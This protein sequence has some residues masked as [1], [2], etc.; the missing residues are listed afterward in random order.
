M[1]YTAKQYNHATPLSSVVA[2]TSEASSVADKKYFT[3]FDNKLDGSYSPVDG[4]VGLWGSE[5]SDQSGVLPSPYVLSVEETLTI[6]AFRLTGSQYSY[7]VAFTVRFY[8][9]ATLLYAITETDNNSIEYIHYLPRTLVVTSYE[10]T[11]TKISEPVSVVMLHNAYNPGYVK[12]ADNVRV[13][14]SGIADASGLDELLRFDALNVAGIDHANYLDVYGTSVDTARITAAETYTPTIFAGTLDTIRARATEVHETVNMCDTHDTLRVVPREPS[15]IENTIEPTKDT[16][17]ASVVEDV[18]HVINEIDHTI[19]ICPVGISASVSTEL[20]NIHSIM[21]APT[22]HIYGKVYITYTD[23][24][25]ASETNI[26]S[27]GSAYNS[28]PG[29]VLDGNSGTGEKLFMLYEN[30]LTGNYVVSDENSQIGWV[31]DQLS[32][33]NGNFSAPPYIRIDISERPIIGLQIVFDETLGGIATHFKVDY[34]QQNGNVISHEVTNNTM[35]TVSIDREVAN[36]S[37][38]VITV[39]SISKA[40]YPVV[41]SEVPTLSTRLYVGY[42]DTSNLISIDLLEELT[43]DDAIEALGGISANMVTINLDN[44][45][46]EFY[47]NN[48]DSVVAS[49]LRRN[50]KIVP[51]LGVEIVPGEIEWYTLGTFWSYQWDVPV[52]KLTAS[53]VGFD[54]IGLLDTTDFRNHHV[55]INKSIGQLI[56]YVLNDAKQ[57]LDFIEYKIDASLYDIVIPY[58]WFEAASHTAALRKISKCY[59]MHVYCDREGA[60]CASPQ[61]LRMDY[62]Y[63]TWSDKTNVISKRYSSLY[64]TLPNIINVEVKNPSVVTDENLI[65]DEL[66]FD[67]TRVPIRTLNF[68]KPYISDIAISVDCD[69]SVSYTYELYSWGIVMNFTGTG[70]VR[71]IKCSGVVLDISRTSTIS[72]RDAASVRLNGA[73]KRDVTSDFIQTSQLADVLLERLTSLAESDKYDV[74]VTYRGDLS[75]TINDPILLLDGIAPD[76]RYNIKRHEL[77]WNGALSGSAYLNT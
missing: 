64:T 77:F 22:R 53:V 29:Q 57:Q 28:Q 44:S 51:W 7:P 32:D 41:I 24:M 73:I 21:K 54:T 30:D 45:T 14:V 69:S 52:E 65:D 74:E 10:V 34:E 25:L 13:Y 62:Y 58:A 36:V 60:I 20:S 48:P 39:Y 49:S 37:A 71:A 18:S 42:R 63:D 75:L 9:N 31:S 35:A 3:L 17:V 26:S 8:N 47:F 40:G 38:I 19:D 43:Y 15:H 61:K 66:V 56:E 11:V 33:E 6:N 46:G 70:N 59:P 2:F 50:R 23:P 67:V 27:S 72:R 5:L 12:R 16:L 76:N 55:Q 68:G 1:S 4:D